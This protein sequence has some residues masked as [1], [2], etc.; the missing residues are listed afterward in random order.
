MPQ[1]EETYIPS[2]DGMLLLYRKYGPEDPEKCKNVHANLCLVHGFG[3]HSARFA[4][5][6]EAFVK[7]DFVVHTVD[8]RGHGYS[9]GPRADALFED[10]IKDIGVL[11]Q[12]SDAYKPLF[13]YGHSMGGLA[14][15]RYIQTHPLSRIEGAIIASPFLRL[16]KPLPRW[17]RFMLTQAAGVLGEFLI[18]SG[19]DPCG[20]SDDHAE[21]TKIFH[22][23]LMLPFMSVRFGYE[24]LHT[25]DLVF[26][27]PSSID[28]PCLFVHGTSDAITC[29]KAT[30][31]FSQKVSTG[32]VTLYMVEGGAH[33]L[34]NDTS[35]LHTIRVAVEWLTER[36]DS[37]AFTVRRTASKRF[38][39][40]AIVD[41]TMIAT[42]NNWGRR[43]SPSQGT[44]GPGLSRGGN[45]L[46]RFGN[47]KKF[48][49]LKDRFMMICKVL[50]VGLFFIP[51]LALFLIPC[52][53]FYIVVAVFVFELHLT[54]KDA[55]GLMMFGAIYIVEMMN[56]IEPEPHVAH[57]SVM[58]TKGGMSLNE[59][60]IFEKNIEELEE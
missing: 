37:D 10:L 21:V 48:F 4:H 51:P 17:K 30:V 38:S 55:K 23:R 26:E 42:G 16:T 41:D 39:R 59:D 46:V 31:E 2:Y 9:G 27:N 45:G 12:K 14:V 22:D 49:P 29:P 8:L 50:A 44:I 43:L 24:L 60:P 36:T 54:W 13:L 53:L 18:S 35:A 3:E 32:D 6:A 28:V 34:H 5:V 58:V 15:L 40:K 11:I 52:H 56:R 33:E 20:L 1:L 47:T 7:K 19:I 25:A 57:P